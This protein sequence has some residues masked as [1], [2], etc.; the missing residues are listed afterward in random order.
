[1]SGV[2][3]DAVEYSA[4]TMGEATACSPECELKD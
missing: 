1:M 2:D 3:G 4:N